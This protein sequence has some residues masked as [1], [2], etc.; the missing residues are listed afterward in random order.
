MGCRPRHPMTRSCRPEAE[1]AGADLTV[2]VQQAPLELQGAHRRRQ[3]GCLADGPEGRVEEGQLERRVVG[4]EHASGQ[5]PAQLVQHLREGP[6]L[7]EVVVGQAVDGD[8]L[9]GV[10]VDYT[11][12]SKVNPEP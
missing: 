3:G 12:V 5:G 8:G 9:A 6:A 11:A 2:T 7:L 4:E 10:V 1:L